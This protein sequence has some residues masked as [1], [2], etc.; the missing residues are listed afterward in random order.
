MANEV[1]RQLML[2][3]PA[4]NQLDAETSFVSDQLAGLLGQ[5][6]TTLVLS[7][8]IQGLIEEIAQRMGLDSSQFNNRANQGWFLVGNDGASQ[9]VFNDN[10]S[11]TLT[12]NAATDW[13]FANL[14][15]DNGGPLDKITDG[16]GNEKQ[17]DSDF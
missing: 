1:T 14:T 4:E 10:D 15:N 6:A 8:T 17:S 16:T 5:S 13:F 2:L 3:G 7:G 9:T 11:D 12:G